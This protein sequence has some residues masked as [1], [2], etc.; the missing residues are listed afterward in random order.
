MARSINSWYCRIS[1][2]IEIRFHRAAVRIVMGSAT[3]RGG[4]GQIVHALYRP[5]LST[6]GTS[7]SRGGRCCRGD[8]RQMPRRRAGDRRSVDR[9]R[10]R[11][12]EEAAAKGVFG[13]PFVV[14]DGE[15][16][17][18]GSAGPVERWLAT[19]GW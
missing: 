11:A 6:I 17:G 4:C 3:R 13:S 19:G 15:P 2:A 14:V 12:N 9:K 16:L 18:D 5:S 8:L 1:H 7:R 10:S